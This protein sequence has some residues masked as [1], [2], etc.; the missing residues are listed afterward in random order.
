ME[1]S[2]SDLFWPALALVLIFE[3]LMPFVAPRV[4]RRVFSEMLRMRDGQIRFFGLICLGCGVALW[5][6]VA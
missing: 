4:W 1:A 5:W 3:G 2:L 6:W